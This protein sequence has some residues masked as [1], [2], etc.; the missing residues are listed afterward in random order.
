MKRFLTILLLSQF[1]GFAFALADNPAPASGTPDGAMPP[2]LREVSI[3]QNLDKP[4]NLDLKFRDE[5]GK[6]VTLREYFK[7]G[8]PVIVTPVYYGCP[9]L[10][11]QTLNGLLK[12]L[13]VINYELF[14]DFQVVTVSFHPGETPE[15]ALKKKANYADE[16]NKPGT[17]DGWK[18]LTGTAENI[19]PLME[20]LGF[21]YVW[22]DNLKQYAHAAAIMVITPDGKVSKYFY[23]I[24]YSPKD[25]RFGLIEASSNKI[26]TPAEKVLMWCYMYDP[27]TGKYGVYIIRLIRV[28]GI[29]TVLALGTFMF[30]MFRKDFRQAR[31]N[32]PQVR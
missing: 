10:C 21:H 31:A 23:G 29:L 3:E 4:I 15:L 17:D 9:M 5:N 1:A 6:D 32:V 27:M 16:L 25:L 13:R 14:K 26:G 28:G 11:T 2:K 20:Q 8:R 30:I 24:E 19:T 22:D 7:A 18:F 12:T